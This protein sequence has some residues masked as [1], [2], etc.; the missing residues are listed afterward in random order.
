M[1]LERL[2]AEMV[3]QRLGERLGLSASVRRTGGDGKW[4]IIETDRRISVAELGP[5]WEIYHYGRHSSSESAYIAL[6]AW[7]GKS[8]SPYVYI[9]DRS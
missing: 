9:G 6:Y 3:A 2:H 5:E 4:L 8:N 7:R 1:S